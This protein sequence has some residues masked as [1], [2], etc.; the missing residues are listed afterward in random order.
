MQ[1]NQKVGK[2]GEDLACQYL[3]S[4]GYKIVRRNIKLSYQ[5]IDII[6]KIKEK[7][8]FIEVKTRT[9]N[10][11]GQADESFYKQKMKNL[12]KALNIY[13]GGKKIDPDNAR[14]EFIAI[15]IDKIRKIANI[16]HYKDLL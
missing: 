14:L 15:D 2:F 1:Y 13:L 4:K 10:V 11:F 7:I 6:A 3:L 8:I 9:S 16:K 5:E 12:K